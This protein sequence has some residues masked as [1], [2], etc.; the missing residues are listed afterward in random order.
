MYVNYLVSFKPSTDSF[1]KI[2]LPFITFTDSGCTGISSADKKGGAIIAIFLK[3]IFIF[4][5]QFLYISGKINLF[6][7]LLQENIF[8]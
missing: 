3:I 7:E 1:P 5:L 4:I 8:T 6:N 2:I